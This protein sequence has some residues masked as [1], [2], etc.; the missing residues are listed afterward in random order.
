V[1][2]TG[3][4]LIDDDC[5]LAAYDTWPLS[6]GYIG[7]HHTFTPLLTGMG[8]V[9]WRELCWDALKANLRG[10]VSMAVVA[11]CGQMG[12]RYSD[13]GRMTSW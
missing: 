11:C 12:R 6:E 1:R 13:S 5:L 4:G 3:A 10:A 9:S 8:A 7:S 2:E